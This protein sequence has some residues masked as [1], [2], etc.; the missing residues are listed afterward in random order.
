MICHLQRPM[1]TMAWIDRKGELKK[2]LKRLIRLT[3]E[4][5][6]APQANI[7]ENGVRRTLRRAFSF[8]LS[9]G[10]LWST[11]HHDV[12]VALVL[13]WIAATA[14]LLESLDEII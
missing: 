2:R 13:L 12:V 8:G 5:V 6:G 1:V 14:D 10:G 9:A 3:E 11:G 7:E 4:T